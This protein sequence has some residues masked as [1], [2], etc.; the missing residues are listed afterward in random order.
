M[1]HLAEGLTDMHMIHAMLQNV[2]DQF[3]GACLFERCCVHFFMHIFHLK[4]M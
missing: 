4:L 2:Q 1:C 3:E